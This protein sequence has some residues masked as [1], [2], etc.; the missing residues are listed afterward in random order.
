VGNREKVLVDQSVSAKS[1]AV[2]LGDRS[3]SA[4]VANAGFPERLEQLAAH[5]GVAS[6]QQIGGRLG[7]SKTTVFNWRHGISVP[8]RRTLQQIAERTNA[9]VEWLE[10]GEGE[11]L[12][13]LRPLATPG[14]PATLPPRVDPRFTRFGTGSV[15][16]HATP[17][18]PTRAQDVLELE[19]LVVAYE[20]AQ[21]HFAAR[22]V[23]APEP[24][25]LLAM[26]LA[27][28]DAAMQAVAEAEA[29]P[30]PGL[31]PPGA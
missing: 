18:G 11:M 8:Y 26:T 31:V 14:D 24:R 2:R 13:Q 17:E 7:V 19:D 29:A 16:E 28:Y 30:A 4:L 10:R 23:T 25:K 3:V 21:R 22:G 20:S 9:R 27:L 1:D 15:H 6:D 12:Y 5:L